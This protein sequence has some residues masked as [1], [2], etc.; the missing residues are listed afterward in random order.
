MQVNGH[1]AA[2]LDPLGLDNRPTTQELDP[3]FYGFKE[4]DL[5]R[6]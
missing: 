4:T 3:A 5:D 2:K 6:E 1:F